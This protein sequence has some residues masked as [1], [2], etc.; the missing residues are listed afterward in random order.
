[1]FDMPYKEKGY[2]KRNKIVP[3]IEKY[4]GENSREKI[5]KCRTIPLKNRKIPSWRY[6][7][8]WGDFNTG[9]IRNDC[10]VFDR[11]CSFSYITVA[12]VLLSVVISQCTVIQLSNF[13]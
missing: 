13:L 4:Q 8:S 2:S 11:L 12:G 9:S 5:H 7:K 3:K 1:M 6:L 10:H